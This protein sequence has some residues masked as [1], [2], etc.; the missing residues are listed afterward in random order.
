MRSGLTTPR[1]AGSP[2]PAGFHAS[3]CLLDALTTEL[4]CW[5]RFLP[6]SD[7]RLCLRQCNELDV[8]HA[9]SSLC[10]SRDQVS[11][12]H[13]WG[14][15][16]AGAGVPAHPPHCPQSAADVIACPDP[17]DM[18]AGLLRVAGLRE[19]SPHRGLC[20][21]SR[22]RSAGRLL[23]EA[24][25]PG[26]NLRPGNEGEQ[27]PMGAAHGERPRAGRQGTWARMLSVTARQ[28][29]RGLR[30]GSRRAGIPGGEGHCSL[31]FHRDSWPRSA[32]QDPRVVSTWEGQEALPNN[33]CSCR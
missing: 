5:A 9:G 14:H 25:R 8:F 31:G 17:R 19:G 16:P 28:Q 4:Q 18:H 1:P 32:C 29:T 33:A 10:L 23:R 30:T 2:R 21:R 3:P 20:P 12:G 6:G 15:V 11:S 24:L 22:E 26:L 27:C 7:F 13:S